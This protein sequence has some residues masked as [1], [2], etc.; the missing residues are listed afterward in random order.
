MLVQVSQIWNLVMLMIMVSNTEKQ[1]IQPRF[2][3]CHLFYMLHDH[4]SNISDCQTKAKSQLSS[5]T[6]SVGDS[7]VLKFRCSWFWLTEM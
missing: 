2:M 6:K 3:C 4:D 1:N 5:V 7:N